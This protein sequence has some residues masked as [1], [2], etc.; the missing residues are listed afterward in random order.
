MH[1]ALR[2][3]NKIPN[4]HC[5]K[6]CRRCRFEEIKLTP[7]DTITESICMKYKCRILAYG[8]C[9]SFEEVKDD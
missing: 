8:I 2:N 6:C 1:S 4:Y 3:M 5:A 9:D 7:I